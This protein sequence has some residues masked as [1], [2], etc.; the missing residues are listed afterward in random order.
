MQLLVAFLSCIFGLFILVLS[1]TTLCNF[2]PIQRFVFCTQNRTH[3]PGRLLLY[4]IRLVQYRL[5][6]EVELE[7]ARF[8]FIHFHFST[9]CLETYS[10]VSC[11]T[12]QRYFSARLCIM[13]LCVPNVTLHFRYLRRINTHGF[14]FAIFILEY[15]KHSM[16]SHVHLLYF[17]QKTIQ[18]LDK[19]IIGLTT[20][21]SS[22]TSKSKV[23][24]V[25]CILVRIQPF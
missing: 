3:F 16:L 4:S 12:I 17:R 5:Y 19:R 22:F 15:Q 24:T 1:G 14:C 23:C 20:Y 21:V 10:I 11:S 7:L 6:W 18:T 25:V 13:T 2:S 9:M 8:F